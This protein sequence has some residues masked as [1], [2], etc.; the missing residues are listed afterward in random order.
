MLPNW[1]EAYGRNYLAF[2]TGLK[3]DANIQ[4]MER[5]RDVS[6]KALMEIFL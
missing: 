6:V 1:I 2:V 3:L 4:E 5:F